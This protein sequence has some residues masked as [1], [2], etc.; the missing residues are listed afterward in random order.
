MDCRDIEWAAFLFNAMG[1][2][3]YYINDLR[4]VQKKI[5]DSESKEKSD[6]G[7]AVITFL[8]HWRS[9]ASNNLKG[10][11]EKW[12]DQKRDELDDLPF[13]LP[14]VDLDD[15]S[16]EDIIKHL[17]GSLV[18][19]TGIGDTIASKILHILKPDLFVPWDIPIRI[20]YHSQKNQ[21]NNKQ[22]DTVDE[23]F[24]FLKEMQSS[25]KYLM[26]Q[27]KNFV[28]DLNSR[29]KVLYEGNLEKLRRYKTKL[30]DKPNRE[31]DEKIGSYETMVD[32]MERGKT[33][34]K[35]LDE[36]NWITITNGVKIP[37]EW[38]PGQ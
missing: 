10:E 38:S 17:Y 27:D 21:V 4:D 2:D 20:W 31:L 33:I 6:I 11:I 36:Y 25:A 15:K 35:Y 5:K 22:E 26:D 18:C 23:Y 30:A 9:R 7:E 24:L 14:N 19:I 12:Y 34:A 3:G 16:I 29:V 28:S 1:E 13:C 8:N 32:F 37:P